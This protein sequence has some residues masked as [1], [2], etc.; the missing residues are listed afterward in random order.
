ML[1]VKYMYP[2][3]SNGAKSIRIHQEMI[4]HGLEEDTGICHWFT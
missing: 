1:M 3:L 2:S 4:E